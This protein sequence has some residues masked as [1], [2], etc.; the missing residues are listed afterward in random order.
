MQF[1]RLLANKSFLQIFFALLL[2]VLLM[3]VSN[4]IVF[5][6]SI[7]G[8]YEQVKENNKLV[9]TNIVQSFDDVFRDINNLVYSVHSLAYNGATDNGSLDMS[10]VYEMQRDLATLINSSNGNEYMEDVIVFFDNSDLAITKS[11]TIDF[12]ELFNNKYHH[13]LYNSVY[14]RSLSSQTHAMRIYPA[15]D[16]VE[17]FTNNLERRR[18]LIVVAGNNQLSNKNVFIIIDLQKLLRHVR[19]ST[20]MQGS[21]L[22]VLDQNRNVILSTESN[23]NLV[24]MLSGLYLDDGRERTLKQNDYEYNLYKSEYNGFTYIDKVPYQFANIKSVT[25]ANQTILYFT[26]ASAILLSVLLSIYLYKPVREIVLLLGGGY[27]RRADYRSIQSDIVKIQEENESYRSKMGFVDGELRRGMILDAIDESPMSREFE[28]RMLEYFADLFEK[29]FFLMVSLHLQPNGGKDRAVLSTQEVSKLLE[30][31]V[32]LNWPHAVS[33]HAG[34]LR[35]LVLIALNHKSER[36]GIIAALRKTVKKPDIMLLN[37]YFIWAA[38]SGVYESK[39]DHWRS[40]YKDVTDVMMYRNISEKGPV[41]DIESIRRS[42]KVYFP[43]DQFEKLSSSLIHADEAQSIKLVD[44]IMEENA[45]RDIHYHQFMDVAKM[46]FYYMVKHLSNNETSTQQFQDMEAAFINKVKHALDYRSVQDELIR[47]AKY[48][49]EKGKQVPKTKMDQ[50]FIAQYIE[51]NYMNNLYLDHMAALLETTPKYFSNYFKK[52]FG[53]GYVEY[54][55]KVRLSHARKLL[56][57][58]EMSVAEIGEKTG[59][60]NSSTFTTTFK[61]YYGISPSEYRKS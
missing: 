57:E 58:T 33:F 6:N 14:W 54:L 48:V 16:Y 46:M 21:S 1:I 20:M 60:L 38:V 32:K 7:D 4:Y 61:K 2:V 56:K 25:K 36:T 43:F 53:V 12:N 26:I 34:N 30:H 51:K 37:N 5:N 28:Q 35:Y 11:G 55:N 10:S 44:E 9:V 31:Q 18:K 8:I 40:A 23:W 27:N 42:V 47:I 29:R 13:R 50:T 52:T 41:F 45:S 22:I 17:R 15:E 49:C 39:T 3:F 19:Q 59:Y 24:E